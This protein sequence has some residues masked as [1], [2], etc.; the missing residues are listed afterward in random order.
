MSVI[1]GVVGMIGQVQQG[2]QQKAQFDYQAQIQQNNAIIA[3]NNAI[4]AQRFAEDARKRG[5]MEAETFSGKVRQLGGQ[6]KA[7]LAANGV[8]VESGT[9]LDIT[10]ETAEVGQLDALT[11]RA[12]A[13]REAL[14]F[15]QQSVN[16]QAQAGQS[17]AQANLSTLAGANA[18]SAGTGRAFS[19]LLTGAGS[20]ASKWYNFNK[21]GGSVFG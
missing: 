9:A 10:A 20:V 6:Q 21:A 18:A 19:S 15:E 12:N 17:T 14:G 8:L 5:A 13:E 16:F 11:I 7:V 4:T 3:N 2:Q 1:S